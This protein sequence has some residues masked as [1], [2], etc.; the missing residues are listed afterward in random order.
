M[1][2]KK[3]QI[4]SIDSAMA[5]FILIAGLTLLIVGIS[6]LMRTN[7]IEIIEKDLENIPMSLSTNNPEINLIQENRINKEVLHNMLN[8][9]YEELKIK[10]GS[11]KDFCIIFLD[12]QGNLINISK[13]EG[14]TNSVYGIGSSNIKINDKY[15]CGIN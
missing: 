15:N 13:E 3:S 8:M 12:N 14:L 7:K 10:L 6:Q 5:I 2:Q 1:N 9:S 11:T 4:F